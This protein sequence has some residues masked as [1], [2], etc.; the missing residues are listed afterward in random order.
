VNMRRFMV[1]DGNEENPIGT[2]SQ[3]RRHSCPSSQSLA[4]AVYYRSL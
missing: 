2:F 4:Q 3:N 1:V